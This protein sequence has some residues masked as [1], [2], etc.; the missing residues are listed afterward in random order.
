MSDAPIIVTALMADADFTEVNR[1]RRQ[2]FPP[3][4][5]IVP[6]HITLFHHLPP[7]IAPELKYR[8]NLATRNVMPPSAQLRDVMLLERGVAFRVE[9]EGL[10]EIRD[11]LSDAFAGLLTP[12]D[13]QGWRGHVT[14]Q[15]KVEPAIARKLHAQLKE[16]FRPRSLEIEG[17]ASWYYRDGWWEPLSRHLFRG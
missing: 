7:G 14:I 1:L 4:R 2:H 12:Q 10:G 17:L 11:E 6:A 9:S 16:A 8:L 3:D 15:N 13:R 5:N